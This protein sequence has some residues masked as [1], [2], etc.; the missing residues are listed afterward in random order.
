MNITNR[1]QS[2]ARQLRDIQITTVV[3]VELSS[4][5]KLYT[6]KTAQNQEHIYGTFKTPTSKLMDVALILINYAIDIWNDDEFRG[7]QIH[8]ADSKNQLTAEDLCLIP[9]IADMIIQN[10]TRKTEL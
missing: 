4:G 6:V 1:P 8:I 9:I 5:E 2:I 10:I 3:Y 7:K